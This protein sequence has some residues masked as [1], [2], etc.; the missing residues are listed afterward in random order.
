MALIFHRNAADLLFMASGQLHV[1]RKLPGNKHLVLP[2]HYFLAL[3]GTNLLITAED[4][5][6][7]DRE[8]HARSG[9]VALGR[10]R[11]PQYII[12]GFQATHIDLPGLIRGQA[13]FDGRYSFI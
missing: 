12:A 8:F 13:G 2:G 9:L 3:A 10:G 6:A 11:W 4:F 5:Q 1:W 7:C